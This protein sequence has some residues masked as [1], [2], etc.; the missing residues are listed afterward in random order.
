MSP[1]LFYNYLASLMCIF[2]GDLRENQIKVR[3][4]DF[5]TKAMVLKSPAETNP[6]GLVF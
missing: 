4:W 5:E 2:A 1:K 3:E 6:A